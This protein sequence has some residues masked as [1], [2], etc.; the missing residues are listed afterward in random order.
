MSFIVKQ[1]FKGNNE[2]LLSVLFCI[3]EKNALFDYKGSKKN[4]YIHELF[5]C[6]RL[7]T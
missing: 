2:V 3:S 7:S 4:Q 5:F 6:F 1:Q